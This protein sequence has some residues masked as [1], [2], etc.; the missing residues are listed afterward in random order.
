MWNKNNGSVFEL[1]YTN[2]RP[3]IFRQGESVS[4]VRDEYMLQ[5]KQC[6][7]VGRLNHFISY[8]VYIMHY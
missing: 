8:G 7:G 6:S 3:L 4:C 5:D 2:S 1:V